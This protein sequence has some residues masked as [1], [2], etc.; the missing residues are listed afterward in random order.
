M[1]SPDKAIKRLSKCGL[2]IAKVR[3]GTFEDI[4]AITSNKRNAAVFKRSFYYLFDRA[5]AHADIGKIKTQE[6]LYA[7]MILFPVSMLENVGPT[8]QTI[9]DATERM[10]TSI[11]TASRTLQADVAAYLACFRPWFRAYV[12]RLPAHMEELLRD[13][14]AQR[15]DAHGDDEM[16]ELDA[17]IA[18]L[19]RVYVRRVGHEALAALKAE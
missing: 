7:Y 4:M 8:E 12:L 9:V 6:L 13:L 3:A 1:I 11:E 18:P 15:K 19:E 10:L 16:R 17:R 2:T 14:Y 5:D